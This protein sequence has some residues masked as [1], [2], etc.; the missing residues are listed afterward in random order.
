MPAPDNEQGLEVPVRNL[1][2]AY[3]H[4]PQAVTIDGE[5]YTVFDPDGDAALNF[6]GVGGSTLEGSTIAYIVRQA[7]QRHSSI[8]AELFVSAPED[9]VPREAGDHVVLDDIPD[10]LPFLQGLSWE[11]LDVIEDDPQGEYLV[12]SATIDIEALR[13]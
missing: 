3:D 2:Y 10:D 7:L 13:Y 4:P 12:L 11:V 5:R 1:Q 6:S 9:G 8:T